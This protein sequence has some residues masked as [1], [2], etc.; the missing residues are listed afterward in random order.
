[1]AE[2]SKLIVIKVENRMRGILYDS[3]ARRQDAC[4]VKVRS[5][6][7]GPVQVTKGQ[8]EIDPTHGQWCPAV[9][10]PTTDGPYQHLLTLH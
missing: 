9:T 4:V 2:K 7:P 8:P 10:A 6:A 5:A 1:M 3:N